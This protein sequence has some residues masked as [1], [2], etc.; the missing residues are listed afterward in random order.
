MDYPLQYVTSLDHFD[1]PAC[2]KV[3]IEGKRYTHWERDTLLSKGI[4][5]NIYLHSVFLRLKH[6]AR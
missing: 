5:Y 6:T 1:H 2:I 3:Q 4:I